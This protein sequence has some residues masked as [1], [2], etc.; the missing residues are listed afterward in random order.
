MLFTYH[1]QGIIT[2]CNLRKETNRNCRDCIYSGKE[3]DKL[4]K[5]KHVERP[6]DLFHQ[7]L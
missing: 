5:N 6:S 2:V 3:C 4:K 1:E 7:G